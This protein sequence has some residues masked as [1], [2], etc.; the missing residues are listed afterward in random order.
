[1]KLTGKVVTWEATSTAIF[2]LR[3]TS[4]IDEGRT[5]GG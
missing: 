3:E 1:M 2:D 5:G 4:M